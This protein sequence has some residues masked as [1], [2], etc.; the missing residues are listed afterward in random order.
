M[1]RKDYLVNKF[2]SMERIQPM[3]DNLLVVGKEE[4]IAFDFGS[5]SISINRLPLHQLLYVAGEEGFKVELKERFLKTYFEENLRLNDMIVLRSLMASYGWSNE[6]VEGIVADQG[7]GQLVKSEIAHYQQ[8][9]VN[10]SAVLC[11]Q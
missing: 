8:R 11:Y 1:S 2:G 10:G 6:K 9:G 7:I 3:I 5:E 4:G